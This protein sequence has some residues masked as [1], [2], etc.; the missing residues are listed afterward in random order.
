MST[1]KESSYRTI[2]DLKTKSLHKL[3]EI[4]INKLF[5]EK[6]EAMKDLEFLDDDDNDNSENENFD[7]KKYKIHKE[8]DINNENDNIIIVSDRNSQAFDSILEKNLVNLE[9]YLKKSK[10]VHKK[11]H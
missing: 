8:K 1:T 2:K 3:D 10:T 6:N 11:F 9:S 4:D 7:I 5:F